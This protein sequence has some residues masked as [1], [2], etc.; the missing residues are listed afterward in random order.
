VQRRAP[1]AQVE[2]VSDFKYLDEDII[3]KLDAKPIHKRK[4]IELV[5]KYH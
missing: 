2:H 3:E 4:L 1:W 5:K